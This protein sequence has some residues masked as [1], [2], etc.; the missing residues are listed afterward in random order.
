MQQLTAVDTRSVECQTVRRGPYELDEYE[1]KAIREG[2]EETLH[3]MRLQGL[4]KDHGTLP[5][6]PDAAAA[7]RFEASRSV[8]GVAERVEFL[9]HEE[10]AG[11]AL[12]R[13]GRPQGVLAQ[14]QAARCMMRLQETKINDLMRRCQGPLLHERSGSVFAPGGSPRLSM[15]VA[16]PA[17]VQAAAAA[18]AA[19]P[20]TPVTPAA[21]ELSPEE[22]AASAE[23]AAHKVD[24]QLLVDELLRGLDG[25]GGGGGSDGDGGGRS[26]AAAVRQ[27]LDELNEKLTLLSRTEVRER[28]LQRHR[29]TML[30]AQLLEADGLRA[31]AVEEA[32]AARRDTGGWNAFGSEVLGSLRE[33]NEKPDLRGSDLLSFLA[34]V[35]D[36]TYR[37][38]TGAPPPE[39]S[40]LLSGTELQQAAPPLCRKMWG[41]E[42][43]VQ[44]HDGDSGDEDGDSDV[45]TEKQVVDAFRRATHAIGGDV[46]VL[47]HMGVGGSATMVQTALL[48][49]R[50][51]ADANAQKHSRCM[52]LTEMLCARVGREGVA[53][54]SDAAC[55]GDGRTDYGEVVR[56]LE[57]ALAG[58]DTHANG[59]A[60]ARLLRARGE[61][62]ADA[63][64]EEVRRAAARSAVTSRCTAIADA[65]DAKLAP[66]RLRRTRLV[67]R[68]MLAQLRLRRLQPRDAA[69]RGARSLG[70]LPAA[71]V[72]ELRRGYEAEVAAMLEEEVSLDRAAQAAAAAQF[73]KCRGAAEEAGVLG[74]VGPLDR[75]LDARASFLARATEK[76]R[77]ASQALVRLRRMI[78]AQAK[79]A[80]A[81]AAAALQAQRALSPRWSGGGSARLG[82]ERSG[83]GSTP[84]RQQRTAGEEAPQ[85]Q[86]RPPH[87]PPPQA[88][89]QQPRSQPPQPPSP[90]WEYVWGS[91]E[92]LPWADKPVFASG[93][94]GVAQEQRSNLTYCTAKLPPQAPTRAKTTGRARRPRGKR[95][96]LRVDAQQLLGTAAAANALRPD[97]GVPAQPPATAPQP[98]RKLSRGGG[99]GPEAMLG[100]EGCLPP[101]LLCHESL[102]VAA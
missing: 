97:G 30:Q 100:L 42:S 80:A 70:A 23:V 55:G 13:R 20:A 44:G 54:E 57:A 74:L 17:V 83:G 46:A 37:W 22:A 35:R 32:A 66:V 101:I 39:Q 96:S 78:S 68:R 49:F 61:W 16:F 6:I 41:I 73:A 11:D 63:A 5:K 98:L 19:A 45:F 9:T 91:S 36:A 71:V 76:M 69:E 64:R 10:W 15:S 67:F 1:I 3:G 25:G 102:R 43:V 82:G 34:A 77:D 79:D 31:A 28:S 26:V 81:A 2:K 51:A 86:P 14:L 84:Q 99:G 59:V 93:R 8:P 87:A 90:K 18:S 21:P 47:D 40:T 65:L 29:E 58:V 92:L 88:S 94:V 24:A 12:G 4:L 85:Q 53:E 89:Q 95:S 52:E 56:R 33:M 62:T 60:A 50:H 48:A 7:R 27:K 72:A 75:V 38:A